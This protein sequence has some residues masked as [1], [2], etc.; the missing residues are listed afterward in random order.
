MVREVL[1]SGVALRINIDATF[2]RNI[3]GSST[4][5]AILCRARSRTHRL[6]SLPYQMLRL[7]NLHLVR[8]WWHNECALCCASAAGVADVGGMT[9][10]PMCCEVVSLLVL[11]YQQ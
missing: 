5:G 3:A 7:L 2:E 9:A 10:A 6:P 1:A 4:T 11:L 8:D